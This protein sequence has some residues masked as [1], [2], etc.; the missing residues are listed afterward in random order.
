MA[1]LAQPV[2]ESRTTLVSYLIEAQRRDGEGVALV[3]V[4]AVSRDD[5]RRECDGLAPTGLP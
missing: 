3:G 5:F 2:S 4:Q 1:V